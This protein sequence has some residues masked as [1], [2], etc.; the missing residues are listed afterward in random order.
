MARHLPGLREWPRALYAAQ[1]VLFCWIAGGCDA[2][3]QESVTCACAAINPRGQRGERVTRINV[4][5]QERV[6]SVDR[7]EIRREPKVTGE[8]ERVM[9]KNY[10]F[11]RW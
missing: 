4:T 8:I 3:G 11:E 7:R 10:I 2:R 9:K 1:E 6:K 5:R